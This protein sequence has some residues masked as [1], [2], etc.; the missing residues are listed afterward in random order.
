V[1]LGDI[2]DVTVNRK[3]P[4]PAGNPSQSCTSKPD[5]IMTELTCEYSIL[6]KMGTVTSTLETRNNSYMKS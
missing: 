4:V 5:A 3:I 1:G 6:K 2:L